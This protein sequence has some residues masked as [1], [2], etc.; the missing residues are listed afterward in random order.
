VYQKATGVLV[1]NFFL[2]GSMVVITYR[3]VDENTM[4]VCIVECEEAH[5]PTIQTGSMCRL[6]A[7]LYPASA[8]RGE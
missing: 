4:A 2:K 8:P 3:K 1:L 6:D 7:N 5:P